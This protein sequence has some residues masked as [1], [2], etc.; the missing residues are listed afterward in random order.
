MGMSLPKD[1]CPEC[2][3]RGCTK[4]PKKPKYRNSKSTA[5]IAGR[6][7]QFD[8]GREEKRFADACLLQRQGFI[9]LLSRQ[10]RFRLVVNGKLIC[11]YVADWQYYDPVAGKMIVVDAKGVRTRAYRIKAKLFAALTGFTITEV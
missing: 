11:T 6:P 5:M 3:E 1:L 8:S 9:S 7:V 10:P 4:H 2:F